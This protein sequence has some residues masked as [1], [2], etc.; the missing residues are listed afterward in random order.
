MDD[1]FHLSID[2]FSENHFDQNEDHATAVQRRE[3]K[4]VHQR[5]A[6]AHDAKHQQNAA[7]AEGHRNFTHCGD[8]R[9]RAAHRPFEPYRAGEQAADGQLIKKSLPLYQTGRMSIG[10]HGPILPKN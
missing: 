10:Q 2:G 4:R 7:E 3:R 9:D 8:A 6:C 5:D 1:G